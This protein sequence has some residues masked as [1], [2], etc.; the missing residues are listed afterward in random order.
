MFDT[1][2]GVFYTVQFI[3]KASQRETAVMSPAQKSPTG[4]K[5]WSECQLYHVLGIEVHDCRTPT[6]L[7]Q[8]AS[9]L[10]RQSYDCPF[11][12]TVSP[13]WLKKKVLELFVHFHSDVCW[14]E[15]LLE[16]LWK[17]T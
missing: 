11:P 9:M 4:A 10:G 3:Q 8:V 13:P 1:Q 14:V 12:A 15:T 7:F 5:S 6:D 2:I 16:T 17:V